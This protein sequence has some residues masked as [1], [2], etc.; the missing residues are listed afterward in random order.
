MR[1]TITSVTMDWRLCSASLISLALVLAAGAPSKSEAIESHSRKALAR[2]AGPESWSL[3][4]AGYG[5]TVVATPG[6]LIGTPRL[7]HHRSVARFAL[8]LPEGA[9][10][11]HP[12]WYLVH[13]DCKLFLSPGGGHDLAYVEAATDGQPAIQ[14]EIHIPASAGDHPEIVKW[15]VLDIVRGFQAHH[16]RRQ[17]FAIRD[18]NFAQYHGVRGGRNTFAVSVEQF[19]SPRVEKLVVRPDSR[20]TRQTAGPSHLHLKLWPKRQE[21]AAGDDATI[22]ARVHDAESAAH[23]VQV[24][25]GYDRHDLKLLSSRRVSLG[26]IASGHAE[27]AR[28]RFRAL[29][30]ATDR[31]TASVSSNYGSPHR[32]VRI[33]VVRPAAN[34]SAAFVEGGALL[35]LLGGLVLVLWLKTARSRPVWS[36]WNIPIGD[37]PSSTHPIPPRTPR[38]Q[39]EQPRKGLDDG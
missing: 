19:G 27:R 8:T 35:A 21:L 3:G 24:A 14:A 13:L 6:E 1:V 32:N 26:T 20:V 4:K 2:E 30:P 38:H 37:E 18:G 25:V 12:D 28:F 29:R 7:H 16:T 5:P 33:R 36:R 22:V 23:N 34:G 31:V 11:G 9:K 17:A 39:N 15:N 10:Q